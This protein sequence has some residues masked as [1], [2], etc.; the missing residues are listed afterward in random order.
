MRILRRRFPARALT[1]LLPAARVVDLQPEQV[2]EPVRQEHAREPARNG[3]VRAALHDPRVAQQLGEQAV[4]ENV[5]RD[6]VDT[7]L[8]L[9]ADALLQGVDGPNQRREIVARRRGVS[10]SDVRGIAVELG[11]RIDQQ[12]AQHRRRTR[13]Q[14][15]VVQRRR[16]LVQRDDVAVRQLDL[17]LLARGEIRVV[18]LALANAGPERRRDRLVP[19]HRDELGAA[20]AQ[21]LVVR[22]GG[23]EEVEVPQKRRIV[24]HRL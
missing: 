7:G 21:D 23:P 24:H 5:Q 9:A 1:I 18:Q 22:F 8:D 10:A 16:V 11:A 12:R 4:R 15:L 19:A 2:A 13:A 6:V 17:A 3:L 20:H 14:V